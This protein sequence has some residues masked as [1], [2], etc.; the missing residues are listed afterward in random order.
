MTL[1]CR[2]VFGSDDI[3]IDSAPTGLGNRVSLRALNYESHYWAIR[4]TLRSDAV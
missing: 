3:V 2:F 4:C 1:S